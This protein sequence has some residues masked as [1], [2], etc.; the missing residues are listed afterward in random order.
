MRSS[1]LCLMCGGW[2]F[3][4]FSPTFPRVRMSNWGPASERSVIIQSVDVFYKCVCRFI[5]YAGASA[6]GKMEKNASIYSQKGR[7]ET[8][9]KINLHLPGSVQTAEPSLMVKA[10]MKTDKNIK[11]SDIPFHPLSKASRCAKL[12]L[13]SPSQRQALKGIPLNF[14][15]YKSILWHANKW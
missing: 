15:A 6:H 7:R 3:P 8:A 10:L 1:K 14:Q 2:S 11:Y 4:S 12:E 9:Q 5:T 13:L